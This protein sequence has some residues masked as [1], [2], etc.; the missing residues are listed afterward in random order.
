M[1]GLV[2][3]TSAKVTYSILAF[4]LQADGVNGG[5]LDITIQEVLPPPPPPIVIRTV[6]PVGRLNAK[7]GSATITGR[8]SCAGVADFGSIDVQLRQVVGRFVISGRGSVS[9]FGCDGS[10]KPWTAI[11][12]ADNGLFKGGRAESATDAFAVVPGLLEGFRG[13]RRE[14]ASLTRRAGRYSVLAARCGAGRRPRPPRGSAL[15][16]DDDRDLRGHASE[17]LD[18]DLVCAE[19]L[20]RLLEVD[21]VAVY[22]DPAA[23]QRTGDALRR[24][25]AVELAAFADLDAH[26]G[27]VLAIRVAAISASSRSRLR[28][29]SRLAMS[30]CQAR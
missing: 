2:I 7:T 26:R 4:D 24:D 19:R 15:G 9:L 29:S 28:L 30:C 23:G 6:H 12:I 13:T 5:M 14:F 16:L 11:V 3:N 10:T 18:R 25:R 1:T 20:E 8:V 17:D 21:L 22:V 27:V